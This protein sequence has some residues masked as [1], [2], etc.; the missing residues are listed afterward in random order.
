MFN[1]LSSIYTVS[2]YSIYIYCILSRLTLSNTNNNS[3]GKFPQLSEQC[4]MLYTNILVVF[5]G[6]ICSN[7]FCFL[8][9]DIENHEYTICL[10]I[11][12]SV[13]CSTYWKGRVS[14]G[15]NMEHLA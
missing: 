4:C 5:V 15:E 14:A 8:H 9:D 11:P 10:F 13:Y 2:V 12:I 1:V 7:L 3:F 6:L